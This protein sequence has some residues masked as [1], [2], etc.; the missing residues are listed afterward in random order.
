MSTRSEQRLLLGLRI[1]E[2]RT[3][4]VALV[5][6]TARSAAAAGGCRVDLD[7]LELIVSELVANVVL[8]ADGPLEVRIASDH[9]TGVLLEVTDATPG[10]VPPPV[11]RAALE[12]TGRGLMVV[13]TL[14]SDWGWDVDA[15]AGTKRVWV[16]LTADDDAVAP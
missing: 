5:R 4:D 11:E 13:A 12:E 7:D 3:D 16:R 14:A 6:R 9:G 15:P 2:P 10:R 8:H 1:E